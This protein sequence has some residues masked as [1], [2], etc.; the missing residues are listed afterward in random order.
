[1]I[2]K[3]IQD[4]IKC[5]EE[6]RYYDAHE[7]LEEVWFPRRFEKDK[8]VKLLKGFINASVSFELMKLRRQKQ[9]A[10]VWANYL[11]YRP[12]LLEVESKYKNEFYKLSRFVEEINNKK[13]YF[14]L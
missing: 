14:S 11:K 9:S 10:K 8:E 7:A 3:K 2:H 5:L 13:K 1:M 6:E 4:F 12:L